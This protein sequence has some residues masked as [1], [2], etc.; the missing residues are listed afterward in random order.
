MKSLRDQL[1][2]SER[3]HVA[4]DEQVLYILRLFGVEDK[5]PMNELVKD[6]T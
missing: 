6:E 1:D 4:L 3:R 2:K 5:Y